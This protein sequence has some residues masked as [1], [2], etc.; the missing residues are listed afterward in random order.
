VL[1]DLEER[2]GDPPARLRLHDHAV[3]ETGGNGGKQKPR[4]T[5]AALEARPVE[6][7]VDALERRR[8]R[9]VQPVGA[10]FLS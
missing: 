5:D 8:D 9:R 4:M 6:G 2:L 1:F 7:G 10:R 3:E